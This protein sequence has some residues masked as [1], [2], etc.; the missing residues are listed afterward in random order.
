V[1]D[2]RLADGGVVL[3]TGDG[4]RTLDSAASPHQPE[5]S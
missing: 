5:P 3:A 4:P 1:V 2:G